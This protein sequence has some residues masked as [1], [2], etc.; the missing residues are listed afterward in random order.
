[1]FPGPSDHLLGTSAPALLVSLV[2]SSLV[3]SLE[4]VLVPARLAHVNRDSCKGSRSCMHTLLRQG[5]SGCMSASLAELA[6]S[7]TEG[8]H[9]P[10][11]CSWCHTSWRLP[12]GA[13][14]R[15][16][17]WAAVQRLSLHA[18]LL[19]P[20]VHRKA[21][22][23]GHVLCSIPQPEWP[24]LQPACCPCAP[25][26]TH[27]GAQ[28]A[29][30]PLR[31]NT[32]AFAQITCQRYGSCVGLTSG[33]ASAMGG[34][35]SARPAATVCRPRLTA[36]ARVL[37]AAPSLRGALGVRG[38]RPSSRIFCGSSSGVCPKAPM[39][40]A[41]YA[42]SVQAYCIGAAASLPPQTACICAGSG[43]ARASAAA[44]PAA[45]VQRILCLG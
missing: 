30:D 9:H 31:V 34:T 1:M 21:Q 19:M 25:G 24:I 28:P 40:W 42:K 18:Q 38:S 11:P 29:V 8:L 16:L 36:G 27:P 7:L 20:H 4:R 32:V 15:T 35:L 43:P 23:P 3:Q 13:A 33:K 14:C 26:G 37:W 39:R 17:C 5:R 22:G 10:H 12:E 45:P 44:L 2:L 6:R 41:G